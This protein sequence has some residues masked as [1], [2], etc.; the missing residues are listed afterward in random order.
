MRRPYFL[1]SC[2]HFS[3]CGPLFLP[4]AVFPRN[5]GTESENLVNE[6]VKVYENLAEDFRGTK[7]FQRKEE[8]LRE[9]ILND[10]NVLY[11]KQLVR[12]RNLAYE[13]FKNGLNRT[14]V[15]LRRFSSLLFPPLTSAPSDQ[16][17][18]FMVT[19]ASFCTLVYGPSIIDKNSPRHFLSFRGSSFQVTSRLEKTV[20]E[21][22]KIAEKKF[23]TQAEAMKCKG[24]RWRYETERGD[25][26]KAMREVATERL[27]MARLQGSYVPGLRY[28]YH[29]S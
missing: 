6:M 11:T 22:I 7:A 4:S 27:Q 15:R 3:C 25:F 23:L 29:P 9:N 16:R 17:P 26:L 18:S 1:M 20:E 10:L 2:S 12:V 14:P 5:F 13:N 21:K 8:E 24:A 28:V 19:V